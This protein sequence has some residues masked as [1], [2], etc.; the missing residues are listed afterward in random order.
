LLA[1]ACAHSQ[2]TP[3][4]KTATLWIGGDVFLG[5]GGR[6]V[7]A[8]IPSIVRGAP[9]IVN[10]EGPVGD[11]TSGGNPPRLTQAP[12]ALAELRTS[13]IAAAGIANNHAGDAGPDGMAATARALAS[14]G[15]QAAGGP[16]GAAVLELGGLR[17]AITAHDLANGVPPHLR[18]D[19]E[20]ARRRADVLVATFHVTGPPSYLPRPE[21]IAA[22][23]IALAAGATVV[24]AHGTHMLARVERRGRAIIAWGLGNLAFACACTDEES[25]ALLEVTLTPGGAGAASIIPIDAGL[26]D[27]PAHAAADPQLTLELLR[28]LGSS[29]LED[30]SAHPGRLGAINLLP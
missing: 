26:G 15:I 6:G 4:T 27:A 3:H 13:G 21:L 28:A 8:N 22:A 18:A 2:P 14:I 24:A 20:A 1:S 25:G 11:G 9:G 5:T 29:P 19:L 16:A 23:D 30:Q 7:L 17:V 10:L 12:A